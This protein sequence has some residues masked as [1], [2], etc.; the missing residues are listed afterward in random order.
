MW[1]QSESR[2]KGIIGMI[3]YTIKRVRL[4]GPDKRALE[5]RDGGV[6]RRDCVAD[7]HLDR[8]RQPLRGVFGRR[9]AR[10]PGARQ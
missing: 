8:A 3:T 6:R 2:A 7:V 1:Q 10:E 4:T 9:G 5:R